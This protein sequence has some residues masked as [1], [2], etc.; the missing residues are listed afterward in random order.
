MSNVPD[1]LLEPLEAPEPV[2]TE[3]TDPSNSDF[4]SALEKEAG[5]DSRLGELSIAFC[6]AW[7]TGIELAAGYRRRSAFPYNWYADRLRAQRRRQVLKAMRAITPARIDTITAN[8]FLQD[9]I[10]PL[11]LRVVV[12]RSWY[13]SDLATSAQSNWAPRPFLPPTVWRSPEDILT[14]DD[15]TTIRN[16]IMAGADAMPGLLS[17]LS[18]YYSL[19]STAGQ[20]LTAA[21]ATAQNADLQGEE[22]SAPVLFG[23]TAN[24]SGKMVMRLIALPEAAAGL[25]TV[26]Q[27]SLSKAIDGVCEVLDGSAT[28]LPAAGTWRLVEGDFPGGSLPCGVGAPAATL[29]QFQAAQDEARRSMRMDGA[30][31]SLS[32]AVALLAALT[33]L[34]AKP[35]TYGSAKVAEDRTAGLKPL[36]GKG[37]SLMKS[38]GE[39]LAAYLRGT[40]TETRKA[41]V[42]VANDDDRLNFAEG[43]ASW[44]DVAAVSTLSGAAARM[45]AW[46]P[47]PES[48]ASPPIEVSQLIGSG[49]RIGVQ[50][51]HGSSARSTA[52]AWAS[53]L[54]GEL[55]VILLSLS[56]LLP[57]N[58]VAHK[59]VPEI[60][61]SAFKQRHSRNGSA[62]RDTVLRSCVENGNAVALTFVN[63]PIDDTGAFE[64]ALDRLAALPTCP[65]VVFADD[66]AMQAILQKRGFVDCG[67]SSLAAATRGTNQNE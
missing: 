46:S 10:L 58:P 20:Y 26:C 24:G 1:F 57:S 48:T 67:V 43:I 23:D 38:K 64:A 45:L 40:R 41:S 51:V 5:N 44:A 55:P 7:L 54:D 52:A 36:G 9:V 19:A 28:R 42:F 56:T 62:A 6:T 50:P 33:G 60:M 32:L 31:G 15:I 53:A 3:L 14:R 39:A 21:W 4:C 29:D 16:M 34:T 49:T 2:V 11:A 37:G 65:V 22:W 8:T 66:S 59:T 13:G 63:G 47:L 25:V 27:D 12:P 61:V 30:S 35:H 17:W 18:G